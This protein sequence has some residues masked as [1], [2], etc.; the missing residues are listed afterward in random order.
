MIRT[1]DTIDNLA[2]ALV[3]AQAAMVNAPKET[4]GQVGS[5]VRFYTDLPT[6]TDLV[7]P[8]LA[9]HGL[10]YVQ[11]PTSAPAGHVGLTTRIVHTSGE[12]LED[13][14]QMPCGQNGAQG[15]GSALTYSRRYALMA[16]LGIAAEDDD[17]AAASQRP[18]N[19]RG[20][21]QSPAP[22]TGPTEAVTKRAMAMFK[23]YGIEDRDE[24]LQL[25][26]YACKRDVKSWSD[27]TAKE[28][29]AVLS[30][31]DSLIKGKATVGYLDDGSLSVK[32]D[33][34]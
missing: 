6:L 14:F 11:L 31:L 30:L 10:A 19:R 18:Q 33:A 28:A 2:A 1:S 34:A 7:R 26:A 21:A 16:A 25:T 15:V 32:G 8:I 24:R 22:R 23:E 17:G 4:K 9:A 27:V 13:E 20:A 5:Q 3:A 29:D 12:W